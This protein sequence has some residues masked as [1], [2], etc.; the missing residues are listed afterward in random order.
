MGFATTA[1]AEPKSDF[2]CTL[3]ILIGPRL[4]AAGAVYWVYGGEP[5]RHEFNRRYPS[6]HAANG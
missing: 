2:P 6:G 4:R 5:Q 1:F 3:R